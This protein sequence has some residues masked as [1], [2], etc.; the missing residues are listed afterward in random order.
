MQGSV[1]RFA[2]ITWLGIAVLAVLTTTA[3]HGAKSADTAA[4]QEPPTQTKF[5]VP[6]LFNGTLNPAITVRSREPFTGNPNLP[7]DCQS[8]AITTERPDAWRCGTADPCFAPPFSLS[9]TVVACSSAPWTNEVV[10]LE[11]SRPLPTPAACRE[12]QPSACPG[13]VSLSGQPWAVELANG[14]RCTHMTGTIST[15][16]GLGLVY[17][18]EGGGSIGVV[19]RDEPFDTSLPQWRA[20]YLAENAVTIEQLG[21]LVVWR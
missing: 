17:G 18:C 19:N 20:F 6:W 7:S 5:F 2:R 15:Q 3:V 12:M 16:A 11:L 21:V 1:H 14:V 10:L 4:A 8:G 9:V 13:P